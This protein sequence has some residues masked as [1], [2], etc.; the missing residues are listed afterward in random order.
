[1]PYI[2]S[3]F[4][5]SW[6]IE[7]TLGALTASEMLGLYP[8]AKLPPPPL[9]DPVEDLPPVVGSCRATF[10]GGN[11]RRHGDRSNV[12][13]LVSG[14][15]PGSTVL[16]FQRHIKTG[17]NVGE[18]SF[19]VFSDGSVEIGPTVAPVPEDWPVGEYFAVAR[20]GGASFACGQWE[21]VKTVPDV[22]PPPPPCDP[23]PGRWVCTMGGDSVPVVDACKKAELEA[24]GY[25]CEAGG[26]SV[27]PPPDGKDENMMPTCSVVFDPPIVDGIAV[28]RVGDRSNVQIDLDGYSPGQLVTFLNLHG[29]GARHA[30]TFP[31][32]PDG[33][34]SD[35]VSTVIPVDWDLGEWNTSIQA[36]GVP[37]PCGSF[38]LVAADDPAG[39][40]APPGAFI[41]SLP[42]LAVILGVVAQFF[43]K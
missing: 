20:F 38:R 43:R 32:G 4:G 13:L 35:K 34:Y 10:V 33:S 41:Q 36:N 24:R 6:V 26:D 23:I 42:T 30:T 25:L 5:V 31:V 17:V 27:E 22:P 28:R 7:G 21:L 37:I 39:D 15:V 12:K 19:P 29:N 9:E 8:S 3:P 1:M 14:A 40:P 18:S 2:R 16:F 11:I